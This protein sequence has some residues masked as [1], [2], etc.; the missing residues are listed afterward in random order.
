[1]KFENHRN[2]GPPFLTAAYN[3]YCKVL[4]KVIQ[5]AKK[6]VNNGFIWDGK[7]KSET[8]LEVVR[9]ENVQWARD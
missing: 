2:S 6:K 8:V 5:A 1:M 9:S 4:N 7:G 3:E